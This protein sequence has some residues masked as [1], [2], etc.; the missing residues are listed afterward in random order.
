MDTAP[1]PGGTAQPGGDAPVTRFPD[2]TAWDRPGFLLWHATLRWQR[3]VAEALRPL[4]LTHVQF[5]LLAGT[6]WLTARGGPPSQRE[7]AD[8]AGTDAMMTSQVVRALEQRGLIR[9][10]DD[11]NDARVK[12]LRCTTAGRE[13][14]ARAVTEVQAVDDRFFGADGDRRATVDVLR[15][16]AGRDADGAVT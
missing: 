7:L 1:P 2:R 9:R 8:H 6:A 3:E 10:S 5:V 11:P 12:R 4:E 14:A 13:L 15:G 16:L